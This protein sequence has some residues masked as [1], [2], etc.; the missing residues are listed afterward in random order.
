MK[1][2][3]LQDEIKAKAMRREK[4]RESGG[5]KEPVVKKYQVTAEDMVKSPRRAQSPVAAP[6]LYASAPV[7]NHELSSIK[8]LIEQMQTELKRQR[9][10]IT[11]LQEENRELRETVRSQQ[12]NGGSAY[13]SWP[14]ESP[15]K[16]K[17]PASM[18]PHKV[19]DLIE[20]QRLD[21]ALRHFMK[22][23]EGLYDSKY[24]SVR[25][26]KGGNIVCFK[27]KVYIPE[28]LREKTILHYKRFHPSDTMA[29]AAIRKNCCWP[30]LE[31]DFSGPNQ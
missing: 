2:Q 30:D 13:I 1:P 23:K 8:M 25:E 12:S 9:T 15:V 5:W 4:L 6:P 3:S 10:D 24:M 22:T 7:N 18:E 20:G 28:S 11:A 17:P 31:K 27:K 16:T 14:P 21:K 26:E 19:E 29:L